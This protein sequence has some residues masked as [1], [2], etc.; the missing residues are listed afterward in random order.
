ME[1]MSRMLKQMEE[2]KSQT[3][4]MGSALGGIKSQVNKTKKQ[5]HF[6]D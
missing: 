6:A 1:E 4:S 5:V 2:L 3:D